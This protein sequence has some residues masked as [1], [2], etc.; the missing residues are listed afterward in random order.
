ME[1]NIRDVLNKYKIGLEAKN[2]TIKTNLRTEY[3]EVQDRQAVLRALNFSGSLDKDYTEKLEQ[4]GK[5]IATDKENYELNN[6]NI[7]A[8]E[9]YLERISDPDYL[10]SEIKIIDKNYPMNS[11]M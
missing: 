2:T 8:I 9:R 3:I 6:K 10:D 5:A 4:L 7:C 11:L 1:N